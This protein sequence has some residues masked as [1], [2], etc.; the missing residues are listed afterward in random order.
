MMDSLFLRKKVTKNP[1][2][3]Y[4]VVIVL[5][6]LFLNSLALEL[7]TTN[8]RF[9]IFQGLQKNYDPPLLDLKPF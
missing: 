5:S 8:W 6:P 7:N 9:F 3:T 4:F 1:T 2:Q